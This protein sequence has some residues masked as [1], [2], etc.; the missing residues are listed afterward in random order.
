MPANLKLSS[1]VHPGKKHFLFLYLSFLHMC[2][3]GSLNF[4][5][6]IPPNLLFTGRYFPTLSRTTIMV[7]LG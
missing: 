1:E 2:E 3:H 4:E 5:R 7:K 6:C